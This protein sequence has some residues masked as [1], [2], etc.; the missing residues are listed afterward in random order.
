MHTKPNH[1]N[2]DWFD[3]YDEYINNDHDDCTDELIY[4]LNATYYH[5]YV[6]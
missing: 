2:N 4:W 3:A 1:Y 6:I 5:G